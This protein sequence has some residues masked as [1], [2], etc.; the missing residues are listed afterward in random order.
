[1]KI[2]IIG[3]GSAGFAAALAI[4]KTDRTAEIVFIDKK[5]YD[6]SHPCGMPFYLEGKIKEIKDLKHDL[7]LDKMNIKRHGNSEVTQIDTDNK[8]V[9][10]K[11]SDN[12]IKKEPYDKLII[13]CGAVPFIPS[14]EGVEN[15]HKALDIEDVSRIKEKMGEAKKAVVIGAGAIGLEVAIALKEN[16]ID[17]TIVDVMPSV[18][19]IIIDPDISGTVEE[20]L[21]EKGIKLLF[22]KNIKKIEKERIVLE[23]STIEVD[24]VVLATGVRANILMVEDTGIKFDKGILVDSRMQTDVEDVFAAGDCIQGKSL[25]T[26]NFCNAQLAST[27]YRQGTVAGI[28]AA[29]SHAVYNGTLGTFVSKVGKLEIAATGFN[30]FLAEKE[31][32]DVVAGKATA[33]EKP[34]WFPGVKKITLKVIADK[35][36]SRILGAQAVGEHGAAS[37]INVISTAIKAGM[38]LNELQDVELAYCP[39]I[40]DVKDVIHIAAELALRRIG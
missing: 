12:E 26:D 25:I 6:I 22:E 10:F 14:I 23:D 30:K 2:V 13:S 21:H 15:A 24:L 16:N 5:S 32:Y 8:V 31:G 18:L 40:S 34:A 28:N 1:M 37:R 27:A 35:K 29:G 4:K 7:G 38:T 33:P 36:S 17:T 19:P 11:D 3:L 9:M 39:A 20:Y